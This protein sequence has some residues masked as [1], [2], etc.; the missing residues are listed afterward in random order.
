M[1]WGLIA[2]AIYA[3]YKLDERKHSQIRAQLAERNSRLNQSS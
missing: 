3:G 1:V 2:A